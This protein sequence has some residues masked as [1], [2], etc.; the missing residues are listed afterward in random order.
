MESCSQTSADALL[1]ALTYALKLKA[2][3]HSIRGSMRLRDMKNAVSRFTQ[4]HADRSCLGCR[5]CTC[6]AN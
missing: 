5:V 2:P 6:R 1:R 4:N 3:R